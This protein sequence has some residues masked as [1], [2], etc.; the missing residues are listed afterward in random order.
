M[1]FYTN[2]KSTKLYREY[3]FLMSKSVQN[4]VQ[5]VK[6]SPKNRQK[7]TDFR[8]L[9]IDVQKFKGFRVNTLCYKIFTN[10]TVRKLS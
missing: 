10:Y 2:L 4:Y 3:Y 5:N 9:N 1:G 8:V 6:K 7:H